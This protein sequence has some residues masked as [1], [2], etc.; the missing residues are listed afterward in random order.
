MFVSADPSRSQ[1]EMNT[2]TKSPAKDPMSG[3]LLCQNASTVRQDK[4]ISLVSASSAVS[5]V[6]PLLRM[7][8]G[9]SLQEELWKSTSC[10]YPRDLREE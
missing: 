7:W 8:R 5:A 6:Y 3:A 4:L 9:D 1:Y 10:H 2:W